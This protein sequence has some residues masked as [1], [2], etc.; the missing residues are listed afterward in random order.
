[1]DRDR[2]SHI[3]TVALGDPASRPAV[4]KRLTSGEFGA[5]NHQWSPDGREIFFTADR[6][7]E[8]YYYPGDSDLYAVPVDGGEPRRAVSIDGNI[9]AFAFS[10]DGKRIAFIGAR[11]PGP[12]AP[13]TSRISSSS[14]SVVERRAT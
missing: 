1:M 5:G 11:M 9:G 7:K 4:P 6:R 14:R 13:T 10:S 2:P 8:A 12:S 3:W